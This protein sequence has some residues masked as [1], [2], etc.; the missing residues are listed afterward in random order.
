MAVLR[1]SLWLLAVVAVF[2]SPV[3]AFLIAIS[4]EILICLV[5]EVGLPAVLIILAAG[6]LGRILLSKFWLS[7]VA[8]NFVHD[9]A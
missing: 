7:R 2:L 6:V 9:Q 4:I 8:N 3:V 5:T 1:S